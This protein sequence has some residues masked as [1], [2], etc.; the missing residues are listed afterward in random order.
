MSQSNVTHIQ[1]MGEKKKQTTYR[2]GVSVEVICFPYL[3]A[4]C[5]FS[6]FITNYYKHKFS[7]INE[8]SLL[9]LQ[10]NK[11]FIMGSFSG[12]LIIVMNET[13]PARHAFKTS[14]HFAND[15]SP[16]PTHPHIPTH[17]IT[18]PLFPLANGKKTYG[19][20]GCKRKVLIRPST[21][22]AANDYGLDR[23][24]S[25][26]QQAVPLAFVFLVLAGRQRQGIRRVLLA[27]VPFEAR[28]LGEHPLATD[29]R[30]EHLTIGGDVALQVL[31]ERL[32]SGKRELTQRAAHGLVPLELGL[33][34]AG[35]GHVGRDAVGAAQVRR[36]VLSL[37]ESL[38]TVG[39]LVPRLVAVGAHVAVEAAL[40]REA[41]GTAPARVRLLAGVGA[42]VHGQ[43][44]AEHGRVRAQVAVE[45][46]CPTR[47]RRTPAQCRALACKV[48]YAVL[49]ISS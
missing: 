28:G 48:L 41:A 21:L 25:Q 46:P 27:Y 9:L 24:S 36:Q 6:N 34:H 39:A 31:H 10:K 38:G 29:A 12:K 5:S 43:V 2:R 42:A 23:C 22:E 11:Q 33:G 14:G 17:S 8:I 4:S 26:S 1:G 37:G 40:V 7:Y 44:A 13:L 45:A 15:A 49:E 32:L 47:Q 18:T 20:Q 30:I 19:Q 3:V 35:L 16:N